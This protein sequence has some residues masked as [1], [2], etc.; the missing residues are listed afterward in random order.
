MRL[1]GPMQ[2][3]GTQSRFVERDSGSEPSKSGVIGLI[4]AALGRDRAEPIDDLAKMKMGVR[5][6]NEGARSN[7]YHIA[8][9]SGFMRA[10]GKV[11]TKNAIPSNRYYI[12]DAD[13]L[14]GFESDDRKLLEKIDAALHNPV[15]PI[16]LGR[17]SFVPSVPVYVQDGIKEQNL[18]DALKDYPYKKKK[19][20][21]ETQKRFIVETED[22]IED[23][24]AIRMVSDNPV[25]FES[26]LFLPRN[27][28]VLYYDVEM[29]ED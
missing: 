1:K 14:V 25:S 9:K 4:C 11:E 16:F 7:D 26:R 22:E 27:V 3:W 17:K 13:Y 8:G 29:V 24:V 10:S 28:A 15:W 6:D 23:T 5:V 18:L 2:S 20:N 21:D 19:R 12:A